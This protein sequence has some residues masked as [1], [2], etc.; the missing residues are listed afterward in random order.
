[1]YAW[2]VNFQNEVKAKFGDGSADKFFDTTKG[3]DKNDRQAKLDKKEM[4][5]GKVPDGVSKVD[6][7]HWLR[8]V[9]LQLETTYEFAYPELVLHKVRLSKVEITKSILK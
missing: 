5:V 7:R 6:W 9:E 2:S 3:G 4:L 1:M 8:A